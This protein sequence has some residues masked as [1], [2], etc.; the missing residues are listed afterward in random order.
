MKLLLDTN[1]FLEVLLGQKQASAAQQLLVNG[2]KHG[3][4]L[5]DDYF[6]QAAIFLR[7]P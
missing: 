6:V 1:I 5:S 2:Q 3:L 7:F 4:F